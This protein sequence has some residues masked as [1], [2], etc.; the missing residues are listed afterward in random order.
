MEMLHITCIDNIGL[1]IDG[2]F[3]TIN[4][5]LLEKNKN[6]H[7][8]IK[9]SCINKINELY[10]PKYPYFFM[11]IDDIINFIKYDIKI[12]KNNINVKL[13]NLD[14]IYKLKFIGL[15]DNPVY[16]I[17]SIQNS[18]RQIINK[19]YQRYA[20][21][22]SSIFN[23]NNIDLNIDMIISNCNFKLTNINE[24]HCILSNSNKF[25][26]FCVM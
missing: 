11:N 9:I 14:A 22:Y 12:D 19:L 24:I 4:F 5:E 23:Y 1:T 8:K 25:N 16:C 7:D 17:C 13:I 26:F 2:E 20:I 6:N 21:S 15:C 3:H 10:N 18:F